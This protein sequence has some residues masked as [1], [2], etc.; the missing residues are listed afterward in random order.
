[1]DIKVDELDKYLTEERNI[2]VKVCHE[3]GIEAD[4]YSCC[5]ECGKRIK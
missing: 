1:M 5:P 4:E 2:D 3:C